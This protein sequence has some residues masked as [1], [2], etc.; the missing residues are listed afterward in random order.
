MAYEFKGNM[1]VT[2]QTRK[3]RELGIKVFE[4]AFKYIDEGK[5]Q[6]PP[7]DLRQG[8]EGAL[9]GIHDLRLNLISGRKIVSQLV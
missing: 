1:G 5:I 2:R 6:L 4:A 9:Q 7:I 8:L 3:Q